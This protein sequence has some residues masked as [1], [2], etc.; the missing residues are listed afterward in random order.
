[1]ELPDPDHAT[2]IMGHKLNETD[3]ADINSCEKYGKIRHK[4]KLLK[5]LL[6]KGN[7]ACLELFRVIAVDLKREDLI[8]TMKLRSIEK[9]NRGNNCSLNKIIFVIIAYI[10]SVL[11]IHVNIGISIFE[12]L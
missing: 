2:D 5:I 12:G 9:V 11:Q 3:I 7:S 10:G 8:E 4:S 6:T 1:M